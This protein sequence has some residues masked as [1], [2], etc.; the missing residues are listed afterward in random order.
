MEAEFCKL[1]GL[2]EELAK[3]LIHHYRM[4]LGA[5]LKHDFENGIGPS[6]G[7][8]VEMAR[9]AV[10]HSLDG[11]HTPL[12]KKLSQFD[13]KVLN[14]YENKMQGSETWRILIPRALYTMSVLRNR[15]G[16]V[17]VSGTRPNEVDARY[18]LGSEK[19]V[20][21]EIIRAAGSAEIEDANR[22][23][24]LLSTRTL[25]IVWEDGENLRSLVDLPYRDS[26]LLLLYV[27][28]CLSVDELVK[29]TEYSSKSRYVSRI[30]KGLHKDRLIYFDGDKCEI[31]PPGVKYIETVLKEKGFLNE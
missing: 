31:L 10:E 28:N 27:R 20:L 29:F 19:W 7:K 6:V 13:Q 3:G 5:F 4:T 9:R 18:L 26:T 11:K 17:H 1:S 22:L 2:P 25:D 23:I 8:F 24:N 15:R 16:M 21:C 14:S 30:L 12:D